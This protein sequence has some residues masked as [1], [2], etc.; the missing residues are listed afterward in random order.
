MAKAT[1][2]NEQIRGLRDD[3]QNLVGHV[4]EVW[5]L[6]DHILTG[7]VEQTTEDGSVLWIAADGAE[8]RKMF[9]RCSGYRIWFANTTSTGSRGQ[10]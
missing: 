10:Q 6:G 4:V 8:T 2:N 3:W 1:S 7:T 5:R 9:D